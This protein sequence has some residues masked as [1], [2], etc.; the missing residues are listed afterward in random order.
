LQQRY[1]LF[2]HVSL[3]L[4]WGLGLFVLRSGPARLITVWFLVSATVY[5]MTEASVESRWSISSSMDVLQKNARHGDL[6]LVS[7]RHVNLVR[8]HLVQYG[9]ET[10]QVVGVTAAPWGTKVHVVH[11]ASL[12]PTEIVTSDQLA[13][14][15]PNRLWM[16]TFPGYAPWGPP[17]EWVESHRVVGADDK[18]YTLTLYQP[19]ANPHYHED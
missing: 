11:E 16:L 18:P 10:I 2:A 7:A 17:F 12:Q 9:M 4:V 1:L 6:I 15:S 8:Y 19:E 3:I 14:L 5:G 13:S